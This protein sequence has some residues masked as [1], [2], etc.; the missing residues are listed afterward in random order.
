MARSSVDDGAHGTVAVRSM[1][2]LT[3]S[4]HRRKATHTEAERE[5]RAGGVVDARH[6]F[7]RERAS[8]RSRRGVNYPG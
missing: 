1:C 7:S 2:Y 5:G 6:L 4:I 8:N 3:Q